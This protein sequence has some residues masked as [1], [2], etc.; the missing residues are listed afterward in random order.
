MTFKEKVQSMTA[1]EIIMAMVESLRNPYVVIDMDTYG[2]TD[3]YGI[4]YG[5][6]ATNTICHIQNV[7]PLEVQMNM[8]EDRIKAYNIPSEELNFMDFFETAIDDLRCGTIRY[9]NYFAHEI[10]IATIDLT[11]DEMKDLKIELP[12]LDN[13]YTEEQLQQYER[14]AQHLNG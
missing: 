8:M 11:K 4:C 7:T 1:S 12:M 2:E 13:D 3:I 9:Y 14:L 10:G 5:C 6:A